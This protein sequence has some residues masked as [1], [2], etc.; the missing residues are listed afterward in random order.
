MSQKEE[1][2]AMM[3][4]LQNY[5]RSHHVDRP[6]VELE[7]LDFLCTKSN[8]G[9]KIAQECSE[10]TVCY[11]GNL[12]YQQSGFICSLDTSQAVDYYIYGNITNGKVENRHVHYMGMVMDDN[13]ADSM[14]GDFGLVWNGM[15]SELKNDDMR[16]SYYKYVCPHKF[17]M[18]AVAGKPVII[19]E[20]AAMSTF[21]KERMCGIVINKLSDIKSVLRSVTTDSYRQYAEHITEIGNNV[22]N[23]FYLTRAIL[24]VESDDPLLA[25]TRS[26]Y[27][28]F[29]SL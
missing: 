23:G 19:H 4:Q 22:S 3:Q 10:W 11:G 24:A 20:C 2:I 5:L 17:S 8:D 21:V 26:P 12:S 13:Y 6:I 18:Y 7:V 27:Y 14:K 25:Y 28:E 16:M 15:N 29:F 9:K 1:L